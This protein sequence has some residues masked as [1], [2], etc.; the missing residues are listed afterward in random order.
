MQKGVGMDTTPLLTRWLIGI[1][2]FLWLFVEY[3]LQ[4]ALQHFDNLHASI[5][6]TGSTA[7]TLSTANASRP[8]YS[9]T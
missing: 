3:P 9:C 1:P 4:A 5:A 7:S 2:S 8:Q 6:L